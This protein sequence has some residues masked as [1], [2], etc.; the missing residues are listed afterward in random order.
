MPFA[1]LRNL[2]MFF[3]MPPNIKNPMKNRSYCRTRERESEKG[4]TGGGRDNVAL[5]TICI[6]V[7]SIVCFLWSL[8]MEHK[9]HL[10]NILFISVGYST[11]CRCHRR[12]NIAANFAALAKI[13]SDGSEIWLYNSEKSNKYRWQLPDTK[14]MVF[15]GSKI[16][17]KALN[18]LNCENK[19]RWHGDEN[20][21]IAYD[22][23]RLPNSCWNVIV[24]SS[25]QQK[26]SKHNSAVDFITTIFFFV[27]RHIH[28]HDNSIV[29]AVEAQQERKD[30]ALRAAIFYRRR[31][32][33][34][35]VRALRSLSIRF[36][37]E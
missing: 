15:F 16:C 24:D 21:F 4:S 13:R 29:R 36:M 26:K 18:E 28:N 22:S 17:R 6:I 5:K 31:S 19:C 8:I 30:N 33:F 20:Y 10:H 27:S 25:E 7:V 11:L 1:L 23:L 35:W 14:K 32:I 37:S 9:M 2:C 3:I 12:R 34:I